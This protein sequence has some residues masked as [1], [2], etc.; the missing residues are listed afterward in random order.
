MYFKCL[1]VE[2]EVESKTIQ[3]W[4]NAQPIDMHC[5]CLTQHNAASHSLR[6]YHSGD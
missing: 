4:P 3:Y 1:C 2:V 5:V 6:K